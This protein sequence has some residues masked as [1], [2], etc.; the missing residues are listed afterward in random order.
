MWTYLSVYSV[1]SLLGSSMNDRQARVAVFFA[2]AFLL[3]FMGARY[4]VGCDFSGYLNRFFLAPE[5][6]DI[7][8]VWNSGEP[9]F[10][11]LIRSVKAFGLD[12]MCLRPP[13]SCSALQ[14]SSVLS[15]CRS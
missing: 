1:F 2:L 3:W 13:L 7:A 6:V 15:G 14:V 12:Y 10:E 8:D 5:A 4:E 9:G 11:L